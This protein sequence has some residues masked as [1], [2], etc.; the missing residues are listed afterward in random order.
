MSPCHT[1]STL[2]LA[3]LTANMPFNRTR[4]CSYP[5]R[6]APWLIMCPAAMAPCRVVPVNSTLKLT[7]YGRHCKP[8]LSQ[9]NYRLSPGL[10]PTAILE[11]VRDRRIGASR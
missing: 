1:G 9:S 10:S 8:G 11:P 7:R 3:E 5:G 4:H 2:R 6:E